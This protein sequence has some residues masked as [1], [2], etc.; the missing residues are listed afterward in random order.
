MTEL[1][2]PYINLYIF[3]TVIIC[4]MSKYYRLMQLLSKTHEHIVSY[5]HYHSILKLNDS[6]SFRMGDALPGPGHSP[7]G[8]HP[9]G[10]AV[11]PKERL[12][13]IL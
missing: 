10:R 9:A 1:H 5:F 2:N 8:L 13:L 7:M 11:V 6:S 4:N 12:A 3:D